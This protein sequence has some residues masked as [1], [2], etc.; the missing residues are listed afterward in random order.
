M[1]GGGG[2]KTDLLGGEE[3][4]VGQADCGGVGPPP[5]VPL[6]EG[7]VLLPQLRRGLLRVLL[8][9]PYKV[10]Q[11]RA[12]LQMIFTVFQEGA[13]K[14]RTGE[15]LVPLLSSLVHCDVY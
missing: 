2:D 14:G 13:H 15:E 8:H 3:V 11:L 12:D 10:P 1:A 5:D 4:S 9:V 6:P 7:G